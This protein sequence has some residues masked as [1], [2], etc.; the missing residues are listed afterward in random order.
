LLNNA[1]QLEITAAVAAA[2]NRLCECSL[3]LRKSQPGQVKSPSGKAASFA[4]A[5][6]GALTQPLPAAELRACWLPAER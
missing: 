6:Q 3:A 2:R 1:H 4:S 5:E